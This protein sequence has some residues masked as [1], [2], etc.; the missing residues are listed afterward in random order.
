M[1]WAERVRILET[2]LEREVGRLVGECL[3]EG[4]DTAL[5]WRDGGFGGG[6]KERN[7]MVE[8]LVRAVGEVVKLGECGKG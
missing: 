3:C 4:G 7:G 1:C 5:A 2:G 8:A 6:F